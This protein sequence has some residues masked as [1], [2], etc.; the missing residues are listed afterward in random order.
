MVL[1]G[2]YV[3]Q[4]PVYN[5][6]LEILNKTSGVIQ[7]VRTDGQTMGNSSTPFLNFVETGDKNVAFLLETSVKA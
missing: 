2:Q 3:Q 5:V 7:A 6:A 4:K 1:V